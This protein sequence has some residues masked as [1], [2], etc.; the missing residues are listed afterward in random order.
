MG[1]KLQVVD[2]TKKVNTKRFKLLPGWCKEAPKTC[3]FLSYPQYGECKCG[4]AKE[5]VHCQHGAIIQVG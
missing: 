3:K 4:V 1:I 2:T 5:H